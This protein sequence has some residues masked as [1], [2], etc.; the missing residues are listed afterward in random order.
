MLR[1]TLIQHGDTAVCWSHN[2]NTTEPLQHRA[3]SQITRD[4]CYPAPHTHHHCGAPG[5]NDLPILLP[6]LSSHS[7]VATRAWHQWVKSLAGQLHSWAGEYGQGGGSGRF[8]VSSAL[9]WNT[10]LLQALLSITHSHSFSVRLCQALGLHMW[11]FS[12]SFLGLSWGSS[13]GVRTT[14]SPAICNW[15]WTSLW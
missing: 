6:E 9:S 10:V 15:I 8:S 3:G 2:A 4:S 14:P 13:F 1:V 5:R 11:V 7:K 12:Q